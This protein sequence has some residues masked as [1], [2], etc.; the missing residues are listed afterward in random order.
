MDELYV[1]ARRVLLDV[2]EVLGVHRDAMVLVGAQA[3]YLRVAESDLAIAPFTT[4]ADLV[5]NPEIL[6]EIPAIE[7]LL[8]NAKY[9]PKAK[10]VVGV[11][12]AKKKTEQSSLVEVPID[13]LVPKTV[14]PGRGRRAAKLPGHSPNA[15]RIVA[16]LEGALVDSDLMKISALEDEDPRVFELQVAGPAAL[17]IAKLHKIEDRQGSTRHNNKDALDIYRIFRGTETRDLSRRYHNALLDSRSKK[18]AQEALT[19]LKEYFV[20]SNATG[21]QMIIRAMGIL[22]DAEETIASN[23]ILVGDFLREIKTSKGSTK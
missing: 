16:G 8:Q 4:D 19:I 12:I 10:D 6:A 3:I 2:L 5:L 7:K 21:I 20:G 14:S 22:G 9:E 17:L 11:W 23:E 1:L 18:V 15:A 13:L